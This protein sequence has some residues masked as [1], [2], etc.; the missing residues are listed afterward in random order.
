MSL[1]LVDG[2]KRESVPTQPDFA[3]GMCCEFLAGLCDRKL[4]GQ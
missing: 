4:S 3:R 1:S 2:A